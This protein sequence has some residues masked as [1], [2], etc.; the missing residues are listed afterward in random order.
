MNTGNKY[1]NNY[2]QNTNR[3][4]PVTDIASDRE[5]TEEKLKKLFLT[6]VTQRKKLIY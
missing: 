2:D 6:C 3:D 1:Y 5:M 4:F